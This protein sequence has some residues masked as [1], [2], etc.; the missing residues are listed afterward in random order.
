[1]M[2]EELAITERRKLRKILWPFKREINSGGGITMNFINILRKLQTLLGKEELI[3]MDIYKEWT[4]TNSQE[5]FLNILENWKWPMHGSVKRKWY[6]G[7]SN[8]TGR[9]HRA[10][11]T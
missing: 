3:F 8:Y 2:M 10:Y 7:T 5:E 9:H 11:S 1:M 4:V 6:S